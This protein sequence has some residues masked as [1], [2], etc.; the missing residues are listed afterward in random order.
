M[1][2]AY[3]FAALALIV[4]SLVVTAWLWPT[5]PEIVPM[6]WNAAGQVDGWGPKW[7]L[8]LLGPGL[9]TATLLIFLALPWL[10][11]RRF[12]V[13]RSGRV[14]SKVML[15]VLGLLA[16]IYG[17]VLWA[18]VQ[19]SVEFD[20]VLLGGISVVLALLGNLMGKL[21]RNFFIGIRTPWTLADEANWYA[22][23]RFGGKVMVATGL[24]G[25]FAALAGAP[26]ALWVGVTLL[27]AL[28]PVGY[29]LWYFRRH[30]KAPG[31]HSNNP[32]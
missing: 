29:S 18:I 6:H 9:I 23:H 14:Y 12:E 17:V 26:P 30:R 27:G 11:P 5:L 13:S 15:L 8:L 4:L 21:R 20:D 24:A 22:T 28:L 3:F 10:S 19:G 7:Q 1:N 16:Y 2:R 32:A 31:G 25:L